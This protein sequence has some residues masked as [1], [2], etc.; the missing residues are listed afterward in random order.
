MREDILR[1][2]GHVE[3]KKKKDKIVKKISEIR[4]ESS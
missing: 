2:Y 3:R 1:R 4:V